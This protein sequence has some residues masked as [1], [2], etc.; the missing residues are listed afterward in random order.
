M[1]AVLEKLAFRA[2]DYVFIQRAR[3]SNAKIPIVLVV[4]I[5]LAYRENLIQH[6]VSELGCSENY[7][8]R[9]KWI[10]LRGDA[11][12]KSVKAVTMK[13]IDRTIPKFALLN[14]LLTASRANDYDFVILC[15]D[16]ITLPENFLDNFL[17]IQDRYDLALAQPSRTHNSYID[18]PIVEQVDA[19]IARQTRFVE[20]GPVVSIRRDILP[21]ITPFDESAPMGWGLDFIWPVI[22]QQNGFRIG[23]IDATPVDHSLRK[24]ISNYQFEPTQLK[25][26]EFLARNA[27]LTKEEAFN[28]VESYPL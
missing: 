21:F 9:Q 11:P 14:H 27:H 26:E 12:S 6:I 4:G 7:I 18:N 23:I 13:R 5:Y 20:I 15:D 8:V 28:V 16:D 2:A 25:M 24:P 1:L 17:A 10:A 3:K 22:A 19:V